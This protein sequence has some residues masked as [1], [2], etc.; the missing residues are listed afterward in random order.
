M[1]LIICPGS[2]CAYASGQKFRLVLS[3]YVYW[4]WHP[5]VVRFQVVLLSWCL[6]FFGV[7]KVG[8]GRG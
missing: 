1:P 5:P 3:F 2:S 6:I 7:S 4:R 8:F